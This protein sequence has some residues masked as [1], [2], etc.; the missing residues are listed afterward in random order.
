M[1]PSVDTET[2]PPSQFASV[3]TQLLNVNLAD[4]LD[5]IEYSG[6]TK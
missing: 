6:E 4:A 3:Q 1:P 2:A 5:G